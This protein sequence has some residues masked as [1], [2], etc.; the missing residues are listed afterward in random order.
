M[1]DSLRSIHD[2][3]F[4][5]YVDELKKE[6]S[7]CQSLLDVGCGVGSPVQYLSKDIHRVGVDVFAPA[8]E[9]SKRRG[10][11]NEYFVMNID[12]I[13][14]KFAADSFDCVLA[15]DVIEHVTKD[16]GLALMEKME[17]IAKHKVIIFTPRGFLPQDE[18]EGNPWQMHKSGWEVA[19][20]RERGYHVIGISGLK[21]VWNIEFLWS[22]REDANILVRVIRKILVDLT[23][24]Y[25]RNH[26]EQAY[27][28]MCIK[29]KNSPQ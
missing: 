2:S 15:S 25:A 12:D 23:Q 11:H 14:T 26:P 24:L 1:K 28:I 13:D 22:K 16:Q 5:S 10:I 27:Q 21:A 4:P 7:D 6:S 19:E 29:T 3:I 18:H 8:I 9:E 20:M 17:R